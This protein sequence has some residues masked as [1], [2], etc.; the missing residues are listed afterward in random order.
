MWRPR[1]QHN[2]VQGSYTKVTYSKQLLKQLFWSIRIVKI[3]QGKRA[4]ESIWLFLFSKYNIE[5]NGSKHLSTLSYLHFNWNL[6]EFWYFSCQL[7][8]ESIIFIF[9]KPFIYSITSSHFFILFSLYSH[10]LFGESYSADS[11]QTN[12]ITELTHAFSSGHDVEKWMNQLMKTAFC[13]IFHWTTHSNQIIKDFHKEL[14][15]DYKVLVQN[16]TDIFLAY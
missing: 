3:I 15:L 14:I 2:S 5:K 9:K 6:F 7:V 10:A 4:I 16:R 12:Q 8:T 1:G 11:K 13:R